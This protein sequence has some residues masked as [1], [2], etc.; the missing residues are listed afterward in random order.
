MMELEG[1]EFVLV[2]LQVTIELRRDLLRVLPCKIFENS[3]S[4]DQALERS[5]VS[6]RHL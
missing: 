6:F 1:M 5:S 3:S 4:L 2:K